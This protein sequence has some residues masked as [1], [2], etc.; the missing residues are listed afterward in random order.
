M[1]SNSAVSDQINKEGLSLEDHEDIFDA[2]SP[3]HFISDQF[4]SYTSE[5]FKL[6]IY[7][8]EESSQ[9]K[10]L[11]FAKKPKHSR[12]VHE[13][14]QERNFDDKGLKKTKYYRRNNNKQRASCE[15]SD[16][17]TLLEEAARRIV[18]LRTQ[19]QVQQWSMETIRSAACM[20]NYGSYGLAGQSPGINYGMGYQSPFFWLQQWPTQASP[21]VAPSVLVPGL[22]SLFSHPTLGESSSHEPILTGF[23]INQLGDF[24]PITNELP[25][26]QASISMTTMDPTPGQFEGVPSFPGIW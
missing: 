16:Q 19:L 25:Q 23:G 3:L 24:E 12:H 15:K 8:S 10:K 22:H 17:A 26:G 11:K 21:Y 6:N 2:L 9:G 5:L 14:T 7:A 20:G 13:R 1:A 4:Y 18:S